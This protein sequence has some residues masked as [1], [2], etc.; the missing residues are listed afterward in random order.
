MA[1]I[2]E[3]PCP[4]CGNGQKTRD[5]PQAGALCAACKEAFQEDLAHIQAAKHL[6]KKE[7]AKKIEDLYRFYGQEAFYR[8]EGEAANGKE[9]QAL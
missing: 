4:R 7:R 9:I 1:G 2:I 3:W 8:A 6:N 5:L